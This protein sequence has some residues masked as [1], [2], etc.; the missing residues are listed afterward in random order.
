MLKRIAAT[1]I[2]I[3]I[4]TL[5]VCASSYL[6]VYMGENYSIQY[7]LIKESEL[8]TYNA[9]GYVTEMP[10]LN[11]NETLLYTD[12]GRAFAFPNEMVDA[13][14]TVGWFMHP[15]KLMYSAD[16]RTLFVN[17]PDIPAY[18]SVGWFTEPVA[19]VTNG[20]ETKYILES[21]MEIYRRSG[22]QILRYG[23]RLYYLGEQIQNFIK[24]KSGKYGVYI[25]NLNNGEQL[26]INDGKYSA[27]SVIKL[28]VM[29]GIYNEIAYGSV[30]KTPTIYKKLT[31]MITISDNYSSNYLVK[32]MGKGNY[33]NG[34]AAENAMSKAMGCENTQHLSLFIGYGDY[35]SYGRNYVSPVDCGIVLEKIYRGELI[36][37]EISAEMMNLLKN[38]QRRNK[39]PYLLPEGTVCANKTGETDTVQSDVGIVFSPNADYIICVLTN[40]A[41]SGIRDI[42]NISRIVYDY[43][44]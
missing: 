14:C 44:N 27:A 7:K 24:G 23:P 13:Q 21:E 25:K 2:V 16:S 4:C 31:D 5:S 37:P 42:Q 9:L 38:Q 39:I 15:R 28:F 22:W 40:N 34:F 36:S 19:L 10:A 43:F 33:K 35:V 6:P 1:A 17:L 18:E 8:P 20:N 29:T 32:T 26:I 12:D 3:V 41:R 11:Q 30:K